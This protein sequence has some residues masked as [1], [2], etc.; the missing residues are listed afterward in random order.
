MLA[1]TVTARCALD[2]FRA[3]LQVERMTESNPLSVDTPLPQFSAIEPD[4]VLP[5]VR[6]AL[7]DY[8]AKIAA[9]TAAAGPRTFANTMLPRE[10]LEHRLQRLWSPVSHLH[11]VKDSD[12]LRAVHAE[13][14]QL[15]S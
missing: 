14:E 13:A 2:F 15:L 4:H 11:A 8:R 6:A 9:L 12:A 5:A 10:A 7:A 3:T 1:Q